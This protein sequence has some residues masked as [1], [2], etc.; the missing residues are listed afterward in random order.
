MK[1]V[2]EVMAIGRTFQESMQKALRGLETD[3]DGLNPLIDQS[4]NDWRETLDEQI[5]LRQPDRIWYVADALRAGYSIDKIHALTAIDKWF[6]SQI[7][8]LIELEQMVAST[9]MQAISAEQLF[10]LKQKGFSDRRLAQL[11]NCAEHTV[12]E[13]R[14]QQAV[15]PVYKRVD[16]CAA[17]FSTSTA[18]LYSSYEQECE[19]EV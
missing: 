14:W 1:S 2:G 10:K 19:A 5:R 3:M 13:Y 17:E 11:L 12:R 8:E 4:K 6:L 16:T 9:A 18:Y 7:E 15:R